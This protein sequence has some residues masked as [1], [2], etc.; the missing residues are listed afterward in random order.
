MNRIAVV[1][2]G[3]VRSF[4][5][6]VQSWRR[7]I[8]DPWRES[9][10]LFVHAYAHPKVRCPVTLKG[11]E[12]LRSMATEFEISYS[13]STFLSAADTHRAFPQVCLGK[14]PL[15]PFAG[16][17]ID[18]FRRRKRAFFMAMSY[19]IVN[20]FDWDLVMFVRPDSAFYAPKLDFQQFHHILTH[21]HATTGRRGLLIPSACNF[22]GV[23]DRMAIGLPAEM[24]LYFDINS[25]L[26]WNFMH[27]NN[28]SYASHVRNERTVPTS[29]SARGNVCGSEVVLG[30]WML[31]HNITQLDPGPMV[32]F[33]TLRPHCGSLYCNSS[34]FAMGPN[35]W[36]PLVCQFWTD[37]TLLIRERLM[38]PGDDVADV[39]SRCGEDPL[40]VTDPQEMCRSHP[41]ERCL[42]GG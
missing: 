14:N 11:I 16:N 3:E 29:V 21:Y 12:T 38:L 30:A 20:N 17:I 6:N 10:H 2:V 40:Y 33:M 15:R 25:T 32:Q 26:A 19:A 18:M 39:A 8:I 5:F 36:K 28:D 22:L 23:C 35:V 34:K 4:Y 24:Q 7:Y 27:F 9:I 37:N 41:G 42:C 13:T 1:T 31:M